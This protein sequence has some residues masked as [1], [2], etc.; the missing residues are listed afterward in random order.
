MVSSEKY[1][2]TKTKGVN[3]VYE[4]D[5]LAHYFEKWGLIKKLS[6]AIGEKIV[7][8]ISKTV[9]LKSTR[10]M[11]VYK[12]FFTKQGME[13][14]IILKIYDAANIRSEIEINIY[15]S[16]YHVMKEFLPR[17]YHIERKGEETWV[18]MEFVRQIR[19]QIT[20]TP[21][22][23]DYI[24]PTLAKL[25]AHTYESNIMKYKGAWG[26][27][28]PVYESSKMK[29]E[30]I[31]YIG[32]TV[33]FLDNALETEGLEHIVKP[34]Y[35][36][37]LKIYDK[38]PDFFPELLANGSAVTHGDLHL[39][40][41][42]SNNIHNGGAWDIQFIDWES[43]KYAPVWFDMIVLV[44]ILLAFRKDWQSRG[45]EIRTHCANLYAKEMEKYGIRFKT[46]PVILYKM[47]YLQRTLEKGLHTQ[48]RRIFDYRGGELLPYHLEKVTTWGEEFGLLK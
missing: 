12:V 4:I 33:D 9:C 38:G 6:R 16:A 26:P 23:F 24:I 46:D 36:S 43:A 28:L 40:N 34:Y 32:R 11:S 47:A 20:F 13:H 48:L 15:D 5:E 22:H 7:V 41:I 30:R 27:W 10:R 25:H 2:E 17:I 3:R 19:G 21:A 14:Q 8:D 18:F 45:E 44:E 42:C 39:Q 35:K 1:V 29:K 37:L 31:K